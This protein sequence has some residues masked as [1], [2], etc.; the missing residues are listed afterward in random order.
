MKRSAFTLVEL[1]IVMAVIAALISVVA[2]MGL[3]ALKQARTVQVATDLRAAMNTVIGKVA[4]YGRFVTAADIDVATGYKTAMTIAADGTSAYN[5]TVTGWGTKFDE[6][7]LEA[8][9]GDDFAAGVLNV[10]VS[11]YI[12]N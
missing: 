5:V 1:L 9:F 10:D 4:A 2:P 7:Y 3:N 12:Y 6:D 8:A 11:S